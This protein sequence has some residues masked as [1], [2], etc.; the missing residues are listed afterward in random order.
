M[1]R[2]S[3]I[4]PVVAMWF[5]TLVWPTT[6]GAQCPHRDSWPTAAWPSRADEY[7]TARSAEIAAL[8]DYAFTVT[9]KDADRVGIRTDG[10]VIVQG[11]NIVYERYGRGFNETNRHLGWSVTKSVTAALVGVGVHQGRLALDASLCD[12]VEPQRA[13][14]CDIRVVDLLEFASGLDWAETYEGESN[15]E[16]STLAMLYGQGYRDM[17]AFVLSHPTRDAPGTTFMYSTGETVVLAAVASGALET[18][19]GELYPWDL[20]FDPL[21]MD[22]TILERDVSGNLVGGAYFFAT[23][24]DYA[25]FGYLFLNDGCWD[26]ERLLPEGWVHDSTQVSA[27]YLLNNLDG[28]DSVQGRQWWINV[29]VPEHGITKPW[30]NVPDDAYVAAGHWGQSITVIPSEDLVIVRTADDRDDTFDRDDFIPLAIAV[31]RAL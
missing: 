6:A 17:V 10:I 21:G 27:P 25:R 23:P 19:F 7:A 12:Y 31:G 5:A 30:P 29:A 18:D 9:G 13:E 4:G 8:D 28:G 11:G 16:S 2:Y 1:K 14:N 26:G 3:V 20:L 24:R 15:Q 22:S